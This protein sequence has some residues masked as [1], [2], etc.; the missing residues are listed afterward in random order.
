MVTEAKVMFLYAEKC[1]Q[2]SEA[3]RGDEKTLSK[4]F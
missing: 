1:Q 4:N 2:C 3:R